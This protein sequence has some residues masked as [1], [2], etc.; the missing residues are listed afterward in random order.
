MTLFT[1]PGYQF[2]CLRSY[3][4]ISL[5][6]TTFAT[7]QFRLF[8]RPIFMIAINLLLKEIDPRGHFHQ[9]KVMLTFKK[10]ILFILIHHFLFRRFC[11]YLS[12]HRPPKLDTGA[13][14]FRR[15]LRPLVF[16]SLRIQICTA[17]RPIPIST[18][19]TI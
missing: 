17:H 15:R 4:L 7:H 5:F 9:F 18:S 19:S 12:S 1:I 14:D 8:R 11:H 2:Q 3:S 6:T 10:K 16:F 13:S